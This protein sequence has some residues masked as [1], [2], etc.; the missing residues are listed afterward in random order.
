MITRELEKNLREAQCLCLLPTVCMGQS[1]ALVTQS[2]HGSLIYQRD[3]ASVALMG[4]VLILMSNGLFIVSSCPPQR[5]GC[6][7]SEPRAAAW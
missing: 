1:D 7:C 6:S 2:R 4:G 5:Y 3:V